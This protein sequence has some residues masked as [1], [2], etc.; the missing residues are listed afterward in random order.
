MKEFCTR[1]EPWPTPLSDNS[2][3]SSVMGRHVK[4]PEHLYLSPP[5]PSS[6]TSYAYLKSTTYISSVEI[7][8]ETSTTALAVGD[9]I[10]GFKT[11]AGKSIHV[12]PATAADPIEDFRFFA[13]S[14][15]ES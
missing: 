2:A 9:R 13:G 4:I 7:F 12:S 15:L 3:A 11:S 10:P 6:P 1:Y 14:V 8:T 5:T